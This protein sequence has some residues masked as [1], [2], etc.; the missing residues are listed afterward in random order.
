MPDLEPQQTKILLDTISHTR[1]DVAIDWL[2]KESE[3]I[4]P[5]L[6]EC[7]SSIYTPASVSV[8][9]DPAEKLASFYCEDDEDGTA[10]QWCADAVSSKI[11]AE[12]VRREPLRLGEL[13][14]W[15]VKVAHSSVVRRALELGQFL[16]STKIPGFGGRPVASMV[17]SGLLGAGL[18]YGAGWVADKMTP[19]WARDKNKSMK[20]RFALA[21]GVLGAGLGATPGLINWHDG[22]SFN[23]P[24]LWTDN[25]AAQFKKACDSFV[26]KMA[27]SPIAGTIGGPSFREDPLIDLNDLGNVMWGPKSDP[28]T[29]AMTIGAMYGASKM[30]DANSRPGYVTPKQTGL[31]AMSMGAAGGGLK[32]YAT[33]YV[34][35]KVLGVMT[36]LPKPAQKKLRQFGLAAGVLKSVVPKLFN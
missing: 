26:E 21:G 14:D 35:G 15:I 9:W 18:G 24:T 3:A 23:D 10:I 34:A 28:Q 12:H 33:G 17:G 4:A 27:Y 7:V 25:P 36:G 13:D 2:V 32:G 29:D 6:R 19:R 11:A 20:N 31:L 8:Y 16:P 1:P 30:P 22:R 5:V